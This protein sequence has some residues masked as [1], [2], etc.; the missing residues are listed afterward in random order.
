MTSPPTIG[1]LL[2]AAGS[3]RRAGPRNKLLQPIEGEPM[4]RRVAR[5]VLDAE[6]PCLVVLGHEADE[7]RHALEGLP[8]RCIYNPAHDEGMASSIV[9]GIDALRDPTPGPDAIAIVLGDMPYLRAVDLRHLCASYHA[10]SP[11]RIVA[12]EAGAGDTRR[13]GNPVLWPRSYFDA[14]TQLEGDRG[15][16]HI[17]RANPDAILRVPI[18][19]EGVLIDIDR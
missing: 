6:L 19:H 1:A 14:L 11:P 15:A 7:V 13:L 2:L 10:C 5:T 3:S 17:L 12:P 8:L 16:R 4:V 18:E 9:A